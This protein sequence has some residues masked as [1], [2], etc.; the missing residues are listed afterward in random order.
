MHNVDIIRRHVLRYVKNLR[1]FVSCLSPTEHEAMAAMTG[2]DGVRNAAAI[3]DAVLQCLGHAPSS[4]TDGAAT[5]RAARGVV[6]TATP[7][8]PEEV[9]AVASSPA[10]SKRRGRPKRVAA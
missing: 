7:M 1:I 4:L 2:S 9:I 3:T 6:A 5:V 10:E 8:E